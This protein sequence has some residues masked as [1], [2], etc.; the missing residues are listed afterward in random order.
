MMVVPPPPDS[1]AAVTMKGYTF[2]W[3]RVISKNHGPCARSSHGVSLVRAVQGEGRAARGGDE[4]QPPSPRRL[5]VVGGENV[6]RTPLEPAQSCWGIDLDSLKWY[7]I[8]SSSVPP[9]LAH[10]QAYVPSTQ[11]VFMFGGRAGVAMNEQAMSDVWKLDCSG[12]P[13]QESWSQVPAVAGSTSPPEARSF[14]RMVAVGDRLYVFGGCGA[15]GRLADL[16]SLDPA[17]GTFVSHGT[18]ALRGRGGPNLLPLA[19]GTQIGV[20]AGFAGVE[21]SDGQIFDLDAGTWVAAAAAEDSSSPSSLTSR[22]EGMRPRSVCVSASFPSAGV[23]VIFGGEVN[24]SDR[25]HEGAGGFANDIVVL[26]EAD[27]SLLF[28]VG[29]PPASED[30]DSSWPCPRGW[31]AADSID[32]GD[33]TGS[34][35]LFGGLTGDDTSPKRLDDL[36]RLDISKASS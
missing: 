14:H 28:T 32:H 35:Y 29:A 25:G 6:A 1:S 20:V 33:G 8:D 11:Q 13:G 36:W 24:P 19:G 5:V 9:R 7:P 3:S 26:N 30:S 22:L 2:R 21:T 23:S 27:G 17:T 4:K 10:A 16:H 34:M 15:S 12:P 18:S 31:A